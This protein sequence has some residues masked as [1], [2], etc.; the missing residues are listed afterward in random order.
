MP[1]SHNLEPPIVE[2]HGTLRHLTCL[3][4]HS[5]LP[6]HTFQAI[7]SNLNLEWFQFLKNAQQRGAFDSDHTREDGI[8]TNPDGDVDLPGAPYTEFRYPPCPECLKGGGVEVDKDGAHLPC[9]VSAAPVSAYEFPSRSRDAVRGKHTKGILKPSVVLFGESVQQDP[10]EKADI[11]VQESER[12]LIVGSSLA[13]YS[14][15]KLVREA[16]RNGKGIGIINLGGVRG[17]GE[18]FGDAAFTAPN[19]SPRLRLDI[20]AADVLAGAAEVLYG[21]KLNLGEPVA[22]GDRTHVRAGG[23][24]GVGG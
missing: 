12:L 8:R 7:L 20:A 24:I 4:C 9:L 23:G 6:R 17:E 1:H 5:F 21:E 16:A 13:T 14:A 2:L 3:T 22:F 15:W 11:L 18:L 19:M 10:R